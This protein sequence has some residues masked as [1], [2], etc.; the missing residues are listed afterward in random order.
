MKKIIT[1]LFAVSFFLT[2]K[3]QTSFACTY[4]TLTVWNDYTKKYEDVSG[5]QEASLFVVGSKETMFTHTINNLES[6]YYV[7]SRE[8][9]AVNDVWTYD[10]VSDVGNNYYY[11]FDLNN[12]EVRAAYRSNGNVYMVVF[13]VKSIW[14]GN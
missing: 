12:Y 2:T 1:L 10:V 14:T 11:V 3:A 9:D 5:Y 7:K 4:R 13:S 6:T 8:Y